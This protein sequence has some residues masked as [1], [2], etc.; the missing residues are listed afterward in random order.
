MT[1]GYGVPGDDAPGTRPRP[2]VAQ[3]AD[4]V[5]HEDRVANEDRRHESPVDDAEERNGRFAQLAGACPHQAMC[6]G[7]AEHA[8]RDTASELAVP[9]ID[10]A[11]V[12]LRVI[13]GETG[14]GHEVGIH[15]SRR[16]P[17][18]VYVVEMVT[19]VPPEM[20][21][22]QVRAVAGDIGVDGVKVGMLG[23][24]PTIDAVQTLLA[25]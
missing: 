9:R 11:R 1:E 16:L 22:A 3:L 8:V 23:D 21:V 20:I 13:A 24:A 5:V 4:A 17:F 7:Q 6:I 14:K 10:V 18:R 15:G 19:P 12:Q 25:E 2:A